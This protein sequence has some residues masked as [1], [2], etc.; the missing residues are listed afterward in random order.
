MPDTR[1]ALIGAGTI[2][3]THVR[4]AAETSGVTIVGIADP[5][6]AAK[7]LADEFAIAWHADHRAL[8]ASARPDGAIVATPNALHVPVA[9]DCIAAG[10][11]VLVEKPIADT[12]TQ[13]QRLSHAAAQAG[14]PLLVG[15]H[16]RHNPIIQRARELLRDGAIG[17]LVA[18]NALS[19]FLK[20]DSYFEIP[21]RRAPGGGPVLINMIHEIDL[22][23][24][25]CG[26][27]ASVQA[28]T[29]NAVRGYAVEDTAATILRLDNGA[30]ITI[31]QSDTAASPWSWDQTAGESR[32][33][34]QTGTDSHFIAGTEGALTLP[35]LTLWRYP[36]AKGWQ[37][38]IAHE[39]ITIEPANPYAAQLRHFAAVI[40]GEV[41]P[42]TSGPD[43]TRTLAA[44]LAVKR[45]AELG[46]PQV[47]PA[48]TAPAPD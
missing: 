16:R 47:L 17:R 25:V 41:A 8:L 38:P 22:I 34:F 6:P 32:T 37:H 23:R 4:A 2:G 3:R 43:G 12:V 35:S 40:R 36:H 39:T 24:F 7:T 19:L 18:A 1:I 10:V 33:I 9:L 31:N 44:T 11:P 27:I 48:S 14:V 45:A 15:H 30:I 46:T 20:P 28:A 42:L 29:S 13:A 21:W 26:E 5:S